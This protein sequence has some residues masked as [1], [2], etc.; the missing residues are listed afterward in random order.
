MK[1]INSINYGGKVIGIALMCMLIVP[2][3]LQGINT[4][5]ECY[6]IFVIAKL[7][8]VIGTGMLLC[9]GGILIIEFRQDKK[10]DTYYSDHKNVKIELENGTWE[11][12]ACGSRTI[13]ASALQEISGITFYNAD[14]GTQG[15]TTGKEYLEL[16]TK[17]VVTK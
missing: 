12:G 13:C 15:W 4:I 8:F 14:G 16:F 17:E 2:A 3:I 9:F 6:Y 11:C 7:L 10:I 5:F 1:K